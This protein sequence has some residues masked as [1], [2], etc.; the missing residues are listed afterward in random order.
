MN[1]IP[2]PLKSGKT[3]ANIADSLILETPDYNSMKEYDSFN[4]R[5]SDIEL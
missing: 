5:A 1:S 3:V 4:M 2:D